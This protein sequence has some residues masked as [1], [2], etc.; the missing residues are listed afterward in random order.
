M[1]DELPYAEGQLSNL[2]PLLS[3]MSTG[4][5]TTPCAVPRQAQPPIRGQFPSLGSYSEGS[6]GAHILD[7]YSPR[8]NMKMLSVWSY[9]GYSWEPG[10]TSR[11]PIAIPLKLNFPC[12]IETS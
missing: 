4:G 5:K 10:S 2:I 8:A 6:V 3:K 7:A 9:G 11:G 12:C 1:A